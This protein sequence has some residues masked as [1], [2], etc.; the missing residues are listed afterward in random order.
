MSPN[1]PLQIKAFENIL[2]YLNY[3]DYAALRDTCRI[4][5][6]LTKRMR[7]SWVLSPLGGAGKRATAFFQFMKWSVVPSAS[8]LAANHELMFSSKAVTHLSVVEKNLLKFKGLT[9]EQKGNP[10]PALVPLSN[11][12][13]KQTFHL[14][15]TKC[16][17]SVN[18]CDHLTISDSKNAKCCSNYWLLPPRDSS[19]DIAFSNRLRE[20]NSGGCNNLVCD[21]SHELPHIELH[22]IN[23]KQARIDFNGVI[24]AIVRMFGSEFV[25]KNEIYIIHLYNALGVEREV[26]TR[27][28]GFCN[29]AFHE[30]KMN[31]KIFCTNVPITVVHVGPND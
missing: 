29:D 19:L 22:Y 11:K 27:H 17:D 31:N 28:V 1:L 30:V 4:M 3:V 26:V 24:L 12:G 23:K 13:T 15:Y 6:N 20:S 21:L 14:H 9:N 18:L 7:D 10:P 8:E 5:H 16:V 25:W 2:S